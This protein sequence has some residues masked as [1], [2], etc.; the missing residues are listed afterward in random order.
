M[1][2]SFFHHC[3][4]IP[5]VLFILLGFALL[6]Q[7]YSKP[8]YWKVTNPTL[9]PSHLQDLLGFT[10]SVYTRDHAL[11]TPKSHVFSPL[12]EWTNTLAA[13]LITPNMGSH[14][15]IYLSKMQENSRSGIPGY[16]VERLILVVQGAVT[17]TNASA[18]ATVVVFERRHA[19][20]ENHFPKQIIGSTDQQPLLEIPGEFHSILPLSELG[21]L[22]MEFSNF[23]HDEF[24]SIKNREHDSLKYTLLIYI[25]DVDV[26]VLL[27]YI[28]YV[29]QFDTIW[30]RLIGMP[31]C[32][33]RKT[34][35]DKRSSW[36]GM[37]K[38]TNVNNRK[39][40]P[41]T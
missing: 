13:Y 21:R 11:I 25:I 40:V 10:H 18:S 4:Y 3:K 24:Y 14:F 27:L 38:L 2:S 28:L 39:D 7:S 36:E 5:L 22:F 31:Q 20:L 23:I 32:L 30:F 6:L 34:F 26:G 12:P 17:L 29:F 41:Q 9:S 16:D 1:A 35:Q 19:S 8:L 37:Y 33:Q 15:A